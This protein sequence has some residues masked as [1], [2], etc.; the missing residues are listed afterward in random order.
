M[1]SQSAASTMTCAQ[2]LE[3]LEHLRAMLLQVLRRIQFY[4][5]PVH[6]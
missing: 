5:Q 1:N 6:R 4:E 3:V 2:V